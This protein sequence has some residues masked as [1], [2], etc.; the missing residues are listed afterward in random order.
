MAAR[1]VARTGVCRDC[2]MQSATGSVL[3][4]ATPLRF[5]SLGDG[6][7]NSITEVTE[8]AEV[9]IVAELAREIWT[10]HYTPII[11]RAQVEYM[12]PKF[13]STEAITEQIRKKGYRYFLTRDAGRV[14]VGYLAVIAN[15]PPG[16]MFLSKIYV[17][18]SERGKGL[19]RMMMEHA[20]TLCSQQGFSPLWLTVNKHNTDSIAAYE[21][22]GF[23]NEG[24]IVQDIGGGFVMD[25]CKMTNC[26]SLS[27]RRHSGYREKISAR[28]PSRGPSPI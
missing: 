16:A 5:H 1:I 17:R 19:G 13:Q 20:I 18:K 27:S 11:G 9:E 2:R 6:Q 28:I 14:P 4:T 7:M 23:V 26:R 12:L 24:P 10:E 8:P 15:E 25:D 21:Q 22:M 3:A